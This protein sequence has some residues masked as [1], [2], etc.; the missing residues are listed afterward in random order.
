MIKSRTAILPAPHRLG[1]L[2]SG[3]NSRVVTRSNSR[4]SPECRYHILG[5]ALEI[6]QEE[7]RHRH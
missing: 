7:G 3:G 5:E 1:G 2:L 4:G 6:L